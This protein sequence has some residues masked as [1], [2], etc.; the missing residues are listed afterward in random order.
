M[1]RFSNQLDPGALAPIFANGRKVEDKK[2]LRLF[3]YRISLPLV[4]LFFAGCA[5]MPVYR[6]EIYYPKIRQPAVTVKLLQTDEDIVISPKES[7]VIRCSR[8]RGDKSVYYASASIRVGVSEDGIVLSERNQGKI[9][10]DLSEA[11]FFPQQDDSYLFLNGRPYRGGVEVVLRP[12]NP[13]DENTRS[14]MV[15]NVVWVED[16][17]KGVVPAEIGKLTEEEIE[18]L[19]A[20]AIAARTYSLSRLGQYQDWGYD[21]EASVLDQVYA[22]L[23]GE[24]IVVNEAIEK[25]AGEVIDYQGKLIDAYYHANSGGKTE[26]VENVWGRQEVPYLVS[27]D[28]DDFCSWAKNYSWDEAWDRKE[29]ERNLS[30]YLDSLRLLPEGGFG[31]LVDLVIKERSP[32]GRIQVLEV[33][34][35]SRTYRIYKDKIRWALRRGSDPD[36]I[37]PSTLFDLEI[38]RGF[39]NSI[40][41]VT[42][43]GRGNGHGIGMCQTGAIG[44]ARE[45]YSCKD[46]LTHYYTGASIIKS[47]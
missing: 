46:I 36:L 40:R 38:E 26:Y 11:S 42:A 13:Q 34:T 5:E 33:V 8:E 31:R 12:K 17:L 21:L 44:M 16:Y 25:T 32:S 15:L 30:A 27:V 45:G 3:L 1:K 20:Q 39:D 22:G 4:F 14:I 28:D 29:L 19:K 7:F 9:E 47:Y 18:A 24:D 10:T 23:D 35:D 43:T 6:E 41:S 37:L 2:R